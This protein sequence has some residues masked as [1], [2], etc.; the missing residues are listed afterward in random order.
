MWQG[1]PDGAATFVLRGPSPI[2]FKNQKQHEGESG[3]FRNV[4][5]EF[6]MRYSLCS[7]LW[8]C[9]LTAV[10]LSCASP[11][12]ARPVIDAGPSRAEVL[13]DKIRIGDS[14][15]SVERLLG[16]PFMM[17]KDQGGD[18]ATYMLGMEGMMDAVRGQ[19]AAAEGAA[20]AQNVLGMVSGIGALAGPA[21]SIAGSI[22]SEIIGAGTSLA[23]AANQPTMPD[24]S[25]IQMILI[26]Y[27]DGVVASV[28]RMNP[29]Q[30]GAG[31]NEEKGD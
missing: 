4:I 25:Q 7:I 6:T 18:Q 19:M 3:M 12:S 8:L 21:G 16:K 14:R 24:P 13:Y 26:T 23:M 15:T 27:N 10:F 20:S 2:F 1:G 5:G 28:Q 17:Q 31:I 9:S 11:Q 29:G 30:I 22:G